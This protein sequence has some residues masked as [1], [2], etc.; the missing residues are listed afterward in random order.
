[1]FISAANPDIG[2]TI[3]TTF[4][5]LGIIVGTFGGI[6]LLGEKKSSY[7]MKMIAIGTILV[8]IGAIIIG[9]INSFA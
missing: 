3:A 1:M 5:Q 8:V 7:Q 6:Y 9:N 4:S 2:Q